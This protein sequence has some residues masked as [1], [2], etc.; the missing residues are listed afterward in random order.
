MPQMPMGGAPQQPMTQQPMSQAPMAGCMAMMQNMMRMG[1]AQGGIQS[2][3][4]NVDFG[5]AIGMGAAPSM[6]SSAARLEGRIAFLRTELSIT[7][8]QAPAWDAFASTLRAGREHLDS[9]R[10]ALQE[11]A[12]AVDPMARLESHE[13]HLRER[14]EAMHM[15]RMAFN[16]LYAQLDDTQK[17]IATATM[18][19]FIGAF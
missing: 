9:A 8:A 10:A 7:D 5:P 1:S 11:G 12:T 2:M 19:P 16:T 3:P 6:G 4:G 17:R 18:L 15:T 14:V 13:R